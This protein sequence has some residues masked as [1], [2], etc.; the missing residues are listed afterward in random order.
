MFQPEIIEMDM[1]ASARPF[2]REDES[3]IALA[4]YRR[5]GRL[6]RLAKL[7]I[8]LLVAVCGLLVWQQLAWH[9][10]EQARQGAALIDDYLLNVEIDL[11][12]IAN[13]LATTSDP[14]P[15]FRGNLVQK[16][17]F[18]GLYL[19]GQDGAVLA[20]QQWVALPSR[21][22]FDEQPWLDPVRQGLTYIG[23]PEHDRQPLP[24][25][26]LAVAVPDA[27]GRFA[28][29]LVAR[30]DLSRLWTQI[31]A[32]QVGKTGTVFVIDS[33][34]RI[35]LHRKLAY[36]RGA[37]SLDDLYPERIGLHASMAMGVLRD[38]DGAI[39][40]S[41]SARAAHG[42]LLAVARQ[43]IRDLVF[44][45]SAL[46][47]VSLFALSGVVYCVR[48]AERFTRHE[49]VAPL[50]IL[51]RSASQFEQGNLTHRIGVVGRY[52]LAAISVLLDQ[53]AARLEMT[54]NDQRRRVAEL[55]ASV[56]FLRRIADSVPGVMFRYR[57]PLDGV[58]HFS[59]ISPRVKIFGLTADA[60]AG[61]AAPFFARLHDQDRDAVLQGLNDS[62][63]TLSLWQTQFRIRQPLGDYRWFEGQATPD[64]EPDGSLVWFGYFADIQ[65]QKETEERIRLM[66]Q[67]DALTGLP[68]R[69]LFDDRVERALAEARRERT[70][71][72]LMFI[73]LDRF[74]PVNDQLGHRVGDLLLRDVAQRLGQCVRESDTVARIGGDEF[75][76]LLRN[77][78]QPEYALQVAEKIRAAIDVP[79][80]IEG[81]EIDIST[82]IGI[83]I[84]PDHGANPIELAQRAD[85]AMYR[86]KERGRNAVS[87]ASV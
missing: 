1:P 52:E 67:H 11:N 23:P 74:K 57:R 81:H 54:I 70:R 59:Y 60:L 62:A 55:D 77:A 2:G 34:E 48:R 26:F 87:L 69:A 27:G 13:Y 41:L 45:L 49:I 51:H 82:S 46:I 66:A 28:R 36:M 76:V 85:E 56:E 3:S 32:L 9:L 75:V 24:S 18:Q 12:T 40:L 20:Q 71:F 44:G 29:S 14:D 50:A 30:I 4:L 16:P 5:V 61:D 33:S 43:P 37:T 42:G 86:S 10:T 19:V 65:T 31:N 15:L 35:V 17:G 53:M 63:A 8:L 47:G 72:A 78:R 84:Y 80:T 7:V 25:L 38:R 64:V 21:L 6:G 39:V 22:R 58:A 68:N 79:F 83:A 73:D